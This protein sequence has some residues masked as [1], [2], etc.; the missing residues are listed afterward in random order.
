MTG[1]LLRRGRAHR[2]TEK[3]RSCDVR[4]C[5]GVSTSPGLRATPEAR[6]QQGSILPESQWESGPDNTLIL[7]FWLPDLWRRKSI[8]SSHPVWYF[9][10]AV[11]GTNGPRT[12]GAQTGSLP[13]PTC[14]CFMH[15]NAPAQR[16]HS[17]VFS[18][19]LPAL[20]KH[21]FSDMT[22]LTNVL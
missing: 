11:L 20:R 5:G 18:H 14:L 4:D 16:T 10:T 19:C 15:G 13:L 9:V 8:V 6:K 21:R 7:D 12:P 1:A 22:L 3:S 2:D 17:V